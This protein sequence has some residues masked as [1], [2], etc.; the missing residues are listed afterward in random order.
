MADDVDILDAADATVTVAADEVGGK[1]HQRMKRTVGADGAATDFIDRYTRQDTFTVA[2]N[3]TTVDASAQGAKQFSLQVKG[4]GAAATAWVV[5]LEISLDNA[6]WTIVLT[7]RSDESGYVYAAVDG[8]TI[9]LPYAAPC[10]YFRTR[11][12]SITLGSATN[13]VATLLGMP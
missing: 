5:V 10:L 1:K 4:T 11:L 12:V 7:H 3:G 9:P 2:A 8:Q 13:V 6:N